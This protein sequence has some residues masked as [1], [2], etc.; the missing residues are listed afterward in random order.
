LG[1]SI[2]DQV[3]LILPKLSVTPLGAFPRLKRMTV[4]GVFEVG[5]QVDAT[6]AYI[7]EL[8]ARLLM[9]YQDT[10]PGL[11][12]Q[13]HDAFVADAIVEQLAESFTH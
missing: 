2:G 8:D 5:A 7:H 10:Y 12:I 4:L 11:Q 13:L 9:R 3:E 6:T 1:L